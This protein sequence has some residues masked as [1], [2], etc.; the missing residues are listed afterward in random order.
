[1]L[2]AGADAARVQDLRPSAGELVRFR[3]RERAQQA[4]LGHHSWVGGE[5]PRHVGPD[6]EPLRLEQ[7]GEVRT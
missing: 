7:A 6:L 4:R 5:H 2:G 3:E 1:M